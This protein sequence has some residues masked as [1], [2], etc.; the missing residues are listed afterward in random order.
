MNSY[1]KKSIVVL[2]SLIILSSFAQERWPNRPIK[3]IVPVAAGGNMDIVARTLALELTKSLGQPVLVENRPSAASLVDTQ[4]VAK[5]A[6]DGYTLLAH[7]SIFFSAPLISVDA[8]YDPV[9]DFAPISLTCKAPMFLVSSPTIPFKNLAD[10][11]QQ[12]KARPETFSVASSGNG[13]TGHIASEV[14]S[15]LA[16]IRLLNVF[17]KGNSQSIVDVMSGQTQ[18]MFDQISTSMAHVRTGKL[19]PL[20]VTSVN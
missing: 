5:A 19:K 18:L 8:G 1:F 3:I 14:F 4:L 20:A 6:P 7:S 17:Y 10:L 11:V 15:I 12:A 9:H 16:G 13:S 2:L